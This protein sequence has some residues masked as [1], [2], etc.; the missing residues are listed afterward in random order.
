L[1]GNLVVGFG[2]GCTIG[3]WYHGGRIMCGSSIGHLKDPIGGLN[4]GPLSGCPLGELPLGESLGCPPFGGWWAKP[5][6]T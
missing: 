3:G 6:S 4:G 1:Y 5:L 2:I